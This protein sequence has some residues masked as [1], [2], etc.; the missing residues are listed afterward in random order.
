VTNFCSVSTSFGRYEHVHLNKDS[1][2]SVDLILTL[3][4]GRVE[5]RC[6]SSEGDFET[7]VENLTQCGQPESMQIAK[8]SGN[9]LLR[10]GIH[11]P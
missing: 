3:V 11:N 2:L 9:L 6:H 1:D 7:T 8:T 4:P 10:Q 5:A